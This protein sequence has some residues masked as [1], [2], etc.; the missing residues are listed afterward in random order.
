M[1][2]GR[3]NILEDRER[4]RPQAGGHVPARRAGRGHRRQERAQDDARDGHQL[5]DPPRDR[6]SQAQLVQ[7]RGRRDVRKR[8]RPGL[9]RRR[10]LGEDGHRRHRVQAALGQGL[11]RAHLRLRQQGDRRPAGVAAPQHGPTDRATRPDAFREARGLFPN[12]AFR[13]G[14]AVPAG[15]V[16]RQA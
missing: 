16:V 9:R 2:G 15:R 11:L 7:G 14:L 10:P 5:R 6:L 1:G 8:H 13:Y 3:R 4:M 12:P